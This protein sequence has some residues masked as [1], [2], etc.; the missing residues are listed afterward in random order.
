[1]H[2]WLHIKDHNGR[3]KKLVVKQTVVFSFVGPFFSWYPFRLPFHFVEP[4]NKN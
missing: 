4:R 2:L 3:S 1:M